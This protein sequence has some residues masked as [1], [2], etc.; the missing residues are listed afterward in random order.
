VF[1]LAGAKSCSSR[2]REIGV[3]A[4]QHM[5]HLAAEMHLT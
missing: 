1:E 4:S 5:H 2:R 3:R